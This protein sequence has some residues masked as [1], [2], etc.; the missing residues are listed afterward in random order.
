GV[1]DG[2]DGV[3]GRDAHPR[4]ELAG[5]GNVFF[6]LVVELR[7]PVGGAEDDVEAVRAVFRIG[8]TNLHARHILPN[9]IQRFRAKYS[10]VSVQIEQ[11]TNS[12]VT[13]WV[14]ARLVHVGITSLP[15]NVP[16]GL[17]TLPAMRLERWLVV[18]HGHPLLSIEKPTLADIAQYRLVCH[19]AR[20]SSGAHIR[21]LFASSGLEP[22]IAVTAMDAS[23]LKE[24]VIANQGVALLH[25]VALGPEDGARLAVIDASHL[26]SG[27]ETNLVIRSGE[28]LRSYAYDFIEGFAPR[29]TRRAIMSV[30]AG[31]TATGGERLHPLNARILPASAATNHL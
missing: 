5:G 23:V 26:A 22:E 4:D 2:S 24:F 17:I 19:S 27:T 3:Q 7:H 9:V 11:G 8:T 18:P 6:Y 29:W 30:A 16:S 31:D 10:D 13:Q 1:A 20:H 15:E 28:Y 14:A 25:R 12:E 21:M